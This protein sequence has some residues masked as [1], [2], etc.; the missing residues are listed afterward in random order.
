M[1]SEGTR[2]VAGA[3]GVAAQGRLSR[4]AL[5]TVPVSLAVVRGLKWSRPPQQPLPWLLPWLLP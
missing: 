4:R 2:V 5:V 1:R 3:Q